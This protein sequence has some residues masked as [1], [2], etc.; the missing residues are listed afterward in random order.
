MNLIVATNHNLISEFY[1]IKIIN[2][3][4]DMRGF[5]QTCKVPSMNENI[6]KNRSVKMLEVAMG[7]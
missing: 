2:E 1:F 7:V 6:S 3:L 5:A 4:R